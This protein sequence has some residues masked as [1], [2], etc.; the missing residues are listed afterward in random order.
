MNYIKYIALSGLIALASCKKDN[1]EYSV[2]RD[3]AFIA[4]TET[5]AGTVATVSVAA[6]NPAGSTQNLNVRLSDVA[7]TDRNFRL[8]PFTAEELATYNKANGTAYVTLDKSKYSLSTETVTVKAGSSISDAVQVTILPLSED[9][10][11]SG[12]MY[13]L[14]LKLRSTDGSS[15]L[16]GGDEYIY[17]VKPTIISS[18]PVLGT[19]PSDGSYR[20]VLAKNINTLTLSQWTVEF[21]VNMTGFGRN[22]QAIFG[23]WGPSVKDEIYIRFGDAATPWNTLQAKF[24]GTQFDKSNTIFEPNKW[25]HVALVYN[26]TT[27]ALYVNGQ[28]DLDT[29]KVA[30]QVFTLGDTFHIVGSG[31]AYFVNGAMLQEL[32]VW[33]V[34]R[35]P[36]QLKEAEY[37]VSSQSTGLLHYWKMNEGSGREFKNAV[38]GAPNAFVY[39]GSDTEATPRWMDNVRSDGAG[40]TKID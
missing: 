32:R 12:E 22:N 19:D 2:L 6:D 24:G 1:A 10:I 17:V 34:A 3:Q 7:H 33:N 28:K 13:T 21:R 23:S 16:A 26:G 20:K 31:G 4:Q 36:A 30:G 40:R 11:D 18:V 39:T 25:Y 15:V 38:T 14:P 35:T 27:V 29:D 8:E 9:E 5:K 37:S